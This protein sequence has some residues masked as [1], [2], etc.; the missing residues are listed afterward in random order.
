MSDSSNIKSATSFA[1]L[2]VT[3]LDSSPTSIVNAPDCV[4]SW[5]KRNR[6]RSRFT[7]NI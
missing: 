5:K 6:A 1:D 7:K 2:A 3:Y 4:F